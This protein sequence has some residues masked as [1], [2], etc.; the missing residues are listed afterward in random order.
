M[1]GG[2]AMVHLWIPP[3]VPLTTWWQLLARDGRGETGG[4]EASL[5]GSSGQL[6]TGANVCGRVS[7]RAQGWL[8]CLGVEVV[9]YGKSFSIAMDVAVAILSIAVAG[10]VF[11]LLTAVIVLLVAVTA[12]PRKDFHTSTASDTQDIACSSPAI[13]D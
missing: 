10:T 12:L 11:A 3:I 13:E 2:M 4:Q 6:E 5:H 1:W 8:Y 7:G 9:L